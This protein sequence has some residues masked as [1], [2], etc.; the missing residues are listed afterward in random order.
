MKK[1][2]ATVKQDMPKGARNDFLNVEI[3]GRLDYYSGTNVAW[4]VLVK[5]SEGGS[6]YAYVEGQPTLRYSFPAIGD[7]R[8]ESGMMEN[9]AASGRAS[10]ISAAALDLQ[11]AARKLAAEAEDKLRNLAQQMAT[12]LAALQ[13]ANDAL[14][15]LEL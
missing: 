15:K 2:L 9:R 7:A 6:I 5:P 8:N 11:D 14:E 10:G 1:T 13:A 12:D 3:I 4:E